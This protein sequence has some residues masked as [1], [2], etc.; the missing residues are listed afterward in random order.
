MDHGKTVSLLLLNFCGQSSCD[1]NRNLVVRSLFGTV[2][3]SSLV[4]MKLKK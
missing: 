4:E 2:H 3:N 1:P